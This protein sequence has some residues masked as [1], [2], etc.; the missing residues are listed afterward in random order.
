MS[1]GRVYIVGAGPGDPGLLTV[2]AVEIIREADVILYDY[3]CGDG[4]MAYKKEGAECI[5]I[6]KRGHQHYTP[7]E[8]INL[9]LLEKAR[10]GAKVLRLKGGDPFVFGRGGEEAE[11][12]REHG[13]PFE[14]VPGVTSS[15]AAPA[16]AG[17]PVTHR[18][19]SASVA[20]VTGHRKAASAAEEIP[21]PNTDTV[22]YLMGVT[23]LAGIV[24][25]LTASGRPPSTPVAIIRWGTRPQQRTVVGTLADIAERAA[26]ERINP[27]AVVVV[28]EVVRLREKLSW[29]EDLPDWTEGLPDGKSVPFPPRQPAAGRF[30]EPNDER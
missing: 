23:N 3:L 13:I 22:V 30:G 20:I 19:C 24:D 10:T 14:V 2:R 6:G 11:F 5:Y 29:Y 25:S 27:P 9:L 21:A 26:R 8:K 28:G 17:I 18:D 15:V 4:F 1:D 12:L 16:Y 7:Q